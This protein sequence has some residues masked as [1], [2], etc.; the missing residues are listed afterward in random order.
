MDNHR[1]CFRHSAL[2]FEHILTLEQWNELFDVLSELG[3][4][5]HLDGEIT[6]D[7]EYQVK[8]IIRLHDE[9]RYQERNFVLKGLLGFHDKLRIGKNKKLTNLFGY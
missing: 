6:H 5:F 7:V 8:D 9:G 2:I 4:W 1:L 3:S